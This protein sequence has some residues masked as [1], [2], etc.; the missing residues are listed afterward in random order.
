MGEKIPPR[1]NMEKM[2]P[3][4]HFGRRGVYLAGLG[5]ERERMKACWKVYNLRDERLFEPVRLLS[6]LR[7]LRGGVCV[8]KMEKFRGWKTKIE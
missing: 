2:S 5:L 6:L 1:L 3:D 4:H 8:W 7:S